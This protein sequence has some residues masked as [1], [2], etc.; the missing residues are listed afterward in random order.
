MTTRERLVHMANQIARNFATQS[1]DDAALAVADHIVMFWDPR[2]KALICETMDA[3]GEGLSPV[4]HAAIVH[5][6]DKGAPP[7]QTRATAY[8]AGNSDAG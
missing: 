3:S 5:L 4:A 2:M 8:Q 1:V 7:S 6:R